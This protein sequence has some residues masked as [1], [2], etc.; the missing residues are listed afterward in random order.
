MNRSVPPTVVIVPGLRDHVPGHW[1]TI[2]A[3]NIA[4]ARTVPPLTNDRLSCDA[5]VSALDQVLSDVSGPVVPVAHSAGVMTT[6][7]WARR[8][9]RPVGGA[10]LAA[11]PDFET[12]LPEGYPTL[13][14]LAEN[15]WKPAPRTPL[16]FP[17]IVAASTNDP[18]ADFDRVAALAAAWGSRLENLGR[19]GHLNPASGYGEWPRAEEFVRDLGRTSPHTPARDTA[20]VPRPL[21]RIDTGRARP[22]P[23]GSALVPSPPQERPSA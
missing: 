5:Q 21:S 23:A 19:V 10:L 17:S 12:P 16:P 15:G 7:H 3:D 22:A 1:Q 9:R 18:L 14:T 6:V 8:H 2:L 13:E 4:D 11:P 20:P